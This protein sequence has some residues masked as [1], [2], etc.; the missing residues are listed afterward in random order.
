MYNIGDCSTDAAMNARANLSES[1]LIRVPADLRARLTALAA[2][3]ERSVSGLARRLL[4]QGL[5]G[6]GYEPP[7]RPRR[8]AST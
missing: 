5:D 4:R 3:E 2:N 1:I 8:G 6:A 7:S